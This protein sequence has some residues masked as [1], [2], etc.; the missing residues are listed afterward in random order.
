M[1]TKTLTGVNRKKL[2][3]SNKTRKKAVSRV[4]KPEEMTLRDWQIELRR[5]AG[6]KNTLSVRHAKDPSRPGLFYVYSE[7]GKHRQQKYEVIYQG[8]NCPWNSCQCMDF[9]T[10]G[11]G[12][13][14]HIESVKNSRSELLRTG[15]RTPPPVSGLSIDY[16]QQPHRI[17]LRPGTENNEDTL[18]MASPYFEEG[19]DGILYAKSDANIMQFVSDLLSTGESLHVDR[20]VLDLLS[21]R[22]LRGHINLLKTTLRD[23][24]IQQLIKVKLYPYQI[25]GI[26]FAFSNLKT[27]IA[28]EMGLGKTVQAIGTAELLKKHRLASSALIVCPTSL[29]YQ[30]QRE[31]EKF[32]GHKALVVE[33]NVIKR[34]AQYEDDD[35]YYKIVSYNAVCNDLK[36]GYDLHTDLL[37]LDEVQRLK[38]WDTQMAKSIRLLTSS[39]T[40]ALSGTPLENKLEELYSVVELVDQY[41]LGPYYEFRDRYIKTDEVGMTVGYENLNEIKGR[42]ANTLIRRRKSEVALQMPARQD[43]TVYVAMTDVQS[44]Q[45]EEFRQLMARLVLKW[46]KYKF[47]SETDRLKFMRA[48]C[49]MRMAANSTFIIDQ[50]T[51]EDTKIDELAN[52]LEGIMQSGDEKVVIFSSWERMTRIIAEE[53]NKLGIEYSNLHGGV[54]SEKRKKLVDDF[55]NKPECRVFLSTDAGA[56]GLNLQAGSIIINMDLPWNPAVLEQRVGRIYRLGQKRNIHVINYVSK[57]SIEEQIEDKI[58][59][60][61]ALFSGILDDGADSV[62]L[63]RRNKMEELIEAFASDIDDE[64]NI[65]PHEKQDAEISGALEDK[66]GAAQSDDPEKEKDEAKE[67]SNNE[68]FSTDLTDENAG[69]HKETTDTNQRAEGRKESADTMTGLT[70]DHKVRTIVEQGMS[71]ISN[72]ATMLN[73][74]E[75]RSK[76]VDTLVKTD[77]DTGK[78]TI[79]IPVESKETVATLFNALASLFKK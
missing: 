59:F 18:R 4:V 22:R 77:E 14:K 3:N 73:S 63:S 19:P 67:A 10:S 34:R 12:T 28:D 16:S 9:R 32:T 55:N 5:Q 65:K 2:A 20:D 42:L 76:L 38:N 79:E 64:G 54:P 60:K 57:D 75:E 61:S 36:A 51:R 48:L 1:K 13:C 24:D 62:I 39:F 69:R 31:I 23:A 58:K 44:E 27:I 30:W 21:D 40:V 26:K 56:T 52:T 29:K 66:T 47:L 46:R 49:G 8:D 71:F 72:L 33:G 35:Y 15:Y 6:E 53:L 70:K 45:H 41:V 25:E 68:T 7:P 78:T 43:T 17:R 74:A 50:K 37:V 11:L